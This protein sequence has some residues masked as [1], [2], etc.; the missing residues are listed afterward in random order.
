MESDRT[1]RNLDRKKRYPNNILIFNIS[2]DDLHKQRGHLGT[3]NQSVETALDGILDTLDGLI[4]PD[5][6]VIISSDHG[7]ME[8]DAEQAIPIKDDTRWERFMQGG[9]NPV[10]FRYIVG[11]DQPPGLPN[12]DVHSFEY[13]Q[14]PNGK[15]TVPIGR[16]WFQRQGSY[17]ADRYA[18]G[19]ISLAEMVVP[20]A[21]LQLITEKKIDFEFVDLPTGIAA[22]E[23][24]ECRVSI[25]IR[26][27]GNQPGEFEL[28]CRANTDRV[29]QVAR[30]M[31]VPGSR[32]EASV[33]IMPVMQR[34]EPLTQSLR[35]A[36]KYTTA[37]G[38]PKTIKREIPI[39][40]QKR[41]D[42]VEISFG[43]LDDL[44]R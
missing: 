2:D 20:G 5:D 29:P 6:T 38:K 24:V 17:P 23:G 28:V 19:G 12:Q 26:N 34:G 18:H 40:V 32:S 31:L 36:L 1:A 15:F 10:R 21:V 33:T 30:A 16:K 37:E 3:L 11:V 4:K 35:L 44:E 42:I 13:R 9:E 8:L 14:M 7:F 43:G 39:N 22:D 25:W 27:R 41:R